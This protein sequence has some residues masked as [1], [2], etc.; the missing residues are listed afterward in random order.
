M[1]DQILKLATS[2]LGEQFANNPEIPQ[3]QVQDIAQETGNSIFGAITDQISSGNLGAIQEM[4]SGSQ[5]SSSSPIVNSIASNVVNN[6]VQKLGLNP[7]L[8]QTISAIAVPFVMNMFNSKVS[9]A[10]QTSGFDV[11]SIL[12]SVLNGGQQSSGNSGGGGLLGG[13]LGGLFG[14]NKQTQEQQ[15]TSQQTNPQDMLGSILGQFLK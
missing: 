4:L 12:Q 15:S 1:F 9:N 5:T 2:Q 7:S 13:L 10:Q 8:A 11:N 6:L 3:H 14:G